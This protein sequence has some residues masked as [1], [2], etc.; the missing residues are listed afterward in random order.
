MEGQVCSCGGVPI[1]AFIGED[2]F[3]MCMSCGDSTEAQ[4]RKSVYSQVIGGDDETDEIS[5]VSE[6]YDQGQEGNE[7]QDE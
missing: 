7:G 5:G 3:F 2:V 1:Q 4:S 6:G